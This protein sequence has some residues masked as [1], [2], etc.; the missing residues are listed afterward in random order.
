MAAQDVRA[1]RAAAF[2]LEQSFVP[3]AEVSQAGK[4]GNGDSMLNLARLA[5]T[6][7]NHGPNQA[8]I[9]VA[10]CDVMRSIKLRVIQELSRGASQ[11]ETA[12]RIIRLRHARSEIHFARSWIG[13]IF[14]EQFVRKRETVPGKLKPVRDFFGV[15]AN[16]LGN[17]LGLGYQTNNALR[18]V[19]EH[20]LRT[21]KRTCPA[22]FCLG[23]PLDLRRV[24][25][26][27]RITTRWG[28]AIGFRL[29]PFVGIHSG[30]ARGL[31]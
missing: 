13:F 22:R 7:R 16:Q 2:G 26:R 17:K 10:V 24:V 23:P 29:W 14:P 18:T 9:T 4:T 20:F 19:A 30:C 5:R 21:T 27:R 15:H 3:P 8:L 28:Q 6:T 31:A 12:E 1:P 25:C 11:H